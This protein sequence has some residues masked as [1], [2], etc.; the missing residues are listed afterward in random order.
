M[1][2][3]KAPAECRGTAGYRPRSG[4]GSGFPQQHAGEER[5]KGGGQAEQVGQPGGQQDDDQGQ[6]HEQLG[7]MGGGHLVEQPWQQPTA[8][9]RQADEQQGGLAQRQGQGPVP[10]LFG[11]AGEYRH[12]GQQ[13]HGHHV[14][15]QQ[16]ADRI[17]PVA[18]E[19]F[20][21]AAQLL[22]DDGGGG[23]RQA[24]TEQ[25]RRDQR[26]AGEDQQAA[27]DGAAAQ[28]LQ[29]AQA[30]YHLAQGQH[31]RYGKLQPQGKQQEHH[32]QLR[33]VRQ[34]F[35]VVD[36]AE[37]GRPHQQAHAQVAQHGRQAQAA[38]QGN[39]HQG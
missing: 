32:P 3:K 36:P 27:K 6:Q 21:E 28:H 22:A 18:A 38:E 20:P 10:G 23:Q 1:L 12:Q 11:V 2:T 24:R 39:H 35:V 25:Q 29:A 33:Q 31:F 9:Q 26:Y 5:T 30:E 37:G 16:H 14:L 19:D 8:G 15:E 13:Q 4:A 34:V 17:L 7:G